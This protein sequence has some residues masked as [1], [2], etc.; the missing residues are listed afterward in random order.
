MA[1]MMCACFEEQISRPFI[2]SCASACLVETYLYYSVLSGGLYR[3][4]ICR[5]IWLHI[6]ASLH[7]ISFRLL[8]FFF[9]LFPQ[10]YLNS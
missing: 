6:N 10:D 1:I 2:T 3:S 7:F 9:Q 5:A 4:E 8:D